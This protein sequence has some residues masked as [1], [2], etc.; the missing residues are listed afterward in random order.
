MRCWRLA[1]R[2]YRWGVSV[3]AD[4]ITS[5]KEHWRKKGRIEPQADVINCTSFFLAFWH[6]AAN[7]EISFSRSIQPCKFQWK[8]VIF[9][10]FWFNPH[11]HNR[12]K[13]TPASRRWSLVLSLN[14]KFRI[15]LLIF[16]HLVYMVYLVVIQVLVRTMGVSNKQRIRTKHHTWSH[17]YKRA[18]LLWHLSDNWLHI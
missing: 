7:I 18:P 1:C 5:L 10:Y 2:F 6:L 11:V 12:R 3:V 14:L 13:P 9:E 15:R 17:V 4:V 8:V 16:W